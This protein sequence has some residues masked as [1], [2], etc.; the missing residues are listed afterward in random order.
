MLLRVLLITKLLR[1]PRERRNH[2]ATLARD[3]DKWKNCWRP[4]DR[5]DPG[6]TATRWK[7]TSAIGNEGE[8]K[9]DDDDDY[10]LEDSLSQGDW[11]IEEDPNVDYEMLLR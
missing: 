1:V 5:G 2:W 7:R 10:V 8:K 3:R 11:H 4:L 9:Y 6:M